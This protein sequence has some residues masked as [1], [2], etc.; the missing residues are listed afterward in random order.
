MK[1]WTRRTMWLTVLAALI[2]VAS[3]AMSEAS[4]SVPVAVVSTLNTVP[5]TG[6]AGDESNVVLDACGNIYTIE[7]YGGEV[8]EIPAGGGAATKVIAAGGDNYRPVPLAI[9]PAKGNLYFLHGDTGSLYKVPITNCTPQPASEAT[10]SGIIGNL[11]SISYYWNGSAVATDST[12]D[13]FIATDVA[14]CAG[15]GANISSGP[16]V[17][18]LLVEYGFNGFKTGAV[19]LPSMDNPITSIAIDAGG[20]IYYVSGGALYELQL[21]TAATSTTAP[22][23]SAT[24]VSFGSGYTT[25]VGVAIDGA[26]DMYV[27][28][29]GSSAIY[30]IPYEASALNPNDQFIVA[31]GTNITIA[32]AVA[33]DQFGDLYYANNG[34]SVYKVTLG[35]VN[36]GSTALGATG[37]GTLNVV[38]N[39]DETMGSISVVTGTGVFSNGGGTGTCSATA[40]IQAEGCTVNVSFTPTLPGLAKGGVVLTDA[41]GA[42]IATADISGVG[43]GPGLTV[44]PG[45]VAT[46]GGGYAAPTGVAIDNQGDLFFADSSKNAIL[47]VPTGGT[48][49]VSLGSGFSAPTGV[50]VDGA[51]NV[52]VAD[53]GNSQIVE[54][55]VINGALSTAAQTT[56]I[57]SSTTVAGLTLKNPAGV[58]VDSLGGL[59][60]ADSGNKR[61]VYLPYVGSYDLSLALT[62]GS[63]LAS[64]SAIALDAL[65]NVFIAD[66]GNG[67]VYELTAPISNGVQIII[68]SNLSTPSALTVD[69]SGAVFVVDKGNKKIWRIPNNSGAL[70]QSSADNVIG[71]LNSSELAIIQAPYGV[72]IDSAGNLY[73][74]DNVNAVAYVVS[75][76]GS[77]Q[78]FGQWN[79]GETSGILP[80]FV[81]SS[82]NAALT[83]GT[84]YYT[85]TGDVTQF[86]L[87]SSETNAC[88]SGASVPSGS[89]CS[90]ESSFMPSTGGSYSETYTLST[91][92]ANVTAPQLVFTGSGGVTLP[93][94]TTLAVTS[95]SGNPSYDQ[96]ITLTATVMVAGSTTPVT[97]GAVNLVNAST[98]AIIQTVS[99][100]S[101]A[102]TFTL[103]GGGNLSGGAISFS[104]SYTGGI[105]GNNAYEQSTST[106]TTTVNIQ[107]VAS[108]T[109]LSFATQ[110]PTPASQTAGTAINLTANVSSTFA[111]GLTGSVTF[112]ITDSD[113]TQVPPIT[114]ALTAADA[115]TV[116]TSYIPTAPANGAAFSVVSVVATYNGNSDFAGSSSAAGTFDVSPASGSVSVTASGTSLNSGDSNSTITFTNTSYGGWMGVVGYQCEPSSLPANAIC[117]FSPGQV[118]VHPNTAAAP[119]PPA[120]TQLQVV[121]NNPPNSPLQSSIPW[122][123]GGLAGLSL[124]GTRRRLMRGAWGEFAML[125]G[126][127]LLAVSAGGIMACA[128]SVHTLPNATPT[129]SST[130]I[131]YANADPYLAPPSASTSDP[132]VQPCGIDPKTGVASSNQAPCSQ[133]TYLISLTVQQ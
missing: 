4:S 27:A 47:E 15:P 49:A 7:Q 93:T 95:P 76:T 28:D 117:V 52:Y 72:A 14:C 103:P 104:A 70:D 12:G 66:A 37:S 127:A 29:S 106:P 75:R 32:N 85:V 20:N 77:S 82:G 128:G 132:T 16:L 23:Y 5:A 46:F 18:E 56:L 39:A 25:V 68:A 80:Y 58:T 115:G 63:G 88:A 48:T 3:P 90:L 116:Q 34:S 45:T 86:Q 73:V 13:V 11:G 124:L 26:G 120:T 44:D 40:Y 96:S 133:N 71:Q 64:P 42:A 50:A 123:L 87:A 62:I 31:M 1:G 22:G 74:S 100:A 114:V 126:M 125:I 6:L 2:L 83:L 97:V 36:F 17:N 69:A 55:P 54:I 81:E 110:Y 118:A 24:P 51:G 111:G 67:D 92:A 131:V 121:V 8:D 38:F 78:S 101:G 122:W 35:S 119:Y 60:V 99:L 41:T 94:T 65:G 112:T 61:V 53:T 43:T 79:V 91:N 98:G 84:P 33:V 59:Y 10:F 21:T 105:S 129:G 113:G 57:S 19:L 109:M 108:L 130:I 9:D 107:P 30:E 89:N 102:A